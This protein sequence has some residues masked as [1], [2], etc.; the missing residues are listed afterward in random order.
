MNTEKIKN[1]NTRR[2]GKEIEYYKE[3]D[4]T[5]IYAK[6]IA[7]NENNGKIIIAEVQTNGIGTKGRKWYTGSEKNIAMTIILKPTCKISELDNLT[8]RIA[9]IIKES[10]E[11]LYGY[12]LNIK[13]P[14]DLLLNNKK[15]AGIL[16][17]VSTI[18]EKINY[19]LIGVGFNVNEDCFSKETIDI[20]TSLKKEYNKEF[21]REDIIIRIIE[22]IE[23]EIEK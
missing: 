18:G 5:S 11:E 7:M 23:K 4:S 15:I 6:K 14:N 21:S 19:L 13:I 12:K 17:E 1:A 2:I 8:I 3:I 9:E 10:V 20:A 16:T 22:K